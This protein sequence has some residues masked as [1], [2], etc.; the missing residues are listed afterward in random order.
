MKKF[1]R[2]RFIITFQLLN[3][4][5]F[6]L[7]SDSINKLS[8]L[9]SF[10][11]RI[12]DVASSLIALVLLMPIL[13]L[14][15]V[16]IKITSP[17]SVFFR[18]IRLGHNGRHFELVKFRS[19][20]QDAPLRGP[21]VTGKG[22]SRITPFGNFLRRTKLDELPELWNV[23][24]GDMSLVG[25]RPEVPQYIVGHDTVWEHVLSIK[26]GI[27]DLAT[28]QFRDEE[29]VLES[30]NNRERAYI[31]VVLPI[32]LKLA[33]EYLENRSFWLDIR[34]LVLTV[35]AITFGRIFAKPGRQL[36][37]SAIEKVRAHEQ[38]HQDLG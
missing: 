4:S 20:V 5:Y 19:M 8:E 31:D 1:G 37:E 14:I 2:C 21:S 23:L 15:A 9:Y 26:P 27:T 7:I 33:N 28:L 30:T 18:Q 3:C 24:V 29:T 32:K 35:W 13:L 10:F 34:I 38:Q 25:P 36:A 22:D 11:K 6:T 12:L 17:G 16:L